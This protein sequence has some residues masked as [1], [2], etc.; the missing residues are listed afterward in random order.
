MGKILQLTRK[1]RADIRKRFAPPGQKELNERTLY[2]YL[3]YRSDSDEAKRVRE[4]IILK[5]RIRPR[6][7]M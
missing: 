6:K 5:M 1:E 2:D 7:V 3:H 4:Y